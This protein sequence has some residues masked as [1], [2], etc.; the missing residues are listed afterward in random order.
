[1]ERETWFFAFN[2]IQ[3]D[4]YQLPL[5][6]KEKIRAAEEK[7]RDELKDNTIEINQDLLQKEEVTEIKDEKIL[8]DKDK[9]LSNDKKN[10]VKKLNHL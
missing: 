3:S 10:I 4:Y 2:D 5:E 6:D 7:I 1:M 9:T 8:N